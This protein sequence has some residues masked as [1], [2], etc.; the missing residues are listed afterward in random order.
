MNFLGTDF[1]FSSIAWIVLIFLLLFI[2][3]KKIFKKFYKNSDFNLFIKHT[4]DYLK[5]NHSKIKFDYKITEGSSSEPNPTARAYI[6]IDNLIEQFLNATID[7]NL[8]HQP[9]AQ[10][11]LWDG[12]TF[13]AKPNGTKLPPD[14]A[15]RKN[16]VLQRDKNICQR[17]GT[18][19]KVENAHLFLIKS[20]KNG[21]QFY[22]ENLII[23]CNDCHK[24]TTY[25]NLKYLNIKDELNSFVK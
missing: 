6:V 5:E 11:Q 7:I 23:L 20:I 10:N 21:G 25:K 15:K 1:I 12:Y 22:V 14:W 19:T 3:R 24:A 18:H 13:N 8:S 9:L 2:F 4:K 17:C 16:I